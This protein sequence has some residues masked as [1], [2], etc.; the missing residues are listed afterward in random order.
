M[1]P[2]GGLRRGRAR[3]P[4]PAQAN[5][6]HRPQTNGK[7]ERYYRTLAREWAYRQ[8]WSSNDHRRS[9]LGAFLDRYNYGRPHKALGGKPPISRCPRVNNLAAK[10]S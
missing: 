4:Y 10:N 5:P 9:G 7:V 8:A 3:D 6:P 1:L 2:L